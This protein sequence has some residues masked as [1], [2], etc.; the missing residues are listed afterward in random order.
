MA[1]QSRGDQ[2]HPAA[3]VDTNIPLTAPGRAYPRR[4]REE[5][6]GVDAEGIP[7]LLCALGSPLR[8][9]RS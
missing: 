2:M 6:E 5:A 8:P 4:G 1:F 7:L 3:S 9:G